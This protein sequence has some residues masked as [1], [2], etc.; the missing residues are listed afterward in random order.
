MKKI[1]SYALYGNNKK[2][3][4]GMLENLKINKKK[5]P[6]WEV[7]IYY[8]NVPKEYLKMYN[9]YNPVLIN[10]DDTEYKW[11]GMFWRFRPF[12]LDNVDIFLSRDADS[13]ITDREIKF[14]NE[15]IKSNKCFHIIRDHPG[16]RIEILGGTF[17]VKVKLFNNKYKIKN[18]NEYILE[19][20][21]KFHRELEKQPDQ[22]FLREKIWP[23]IEKDNMAH[24]AFEELRYTND[25]IKTNFV[26]EFIGKDVEIE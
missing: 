25:D 17:A 24:I 23:L 1:I 14:I 12:N 19:Y 9:T 10:C 18:M 11:E 20:R 15:F 16:H 21:T 8:N 3:C 4:I 22:H 6:D 26:P 13:R 5:L 7:Y 2:Y